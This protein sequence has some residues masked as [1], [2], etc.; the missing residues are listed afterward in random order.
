[1]SDKPKPPNLLKIL[2][3]DAWHLA[4]VR[5]VARMEDVIY[6]RVS[7][8]IARKLAVLALRVAFHHAVVKGD[9]LTR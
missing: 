2:E 1:M 7:A 6:G 8:D 9:L 4:R 5:K 3:R